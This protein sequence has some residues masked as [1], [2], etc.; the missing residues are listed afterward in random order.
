MSQNPNLA[1][2]CQA[3]C[4]GAKSAPPHLADWVI[5]T[6]E[7]LAYLVAGASLDENDSGSGQ[8]TRLEVAALRS[9]LTMAAADFWQRDLDTLERQVIALLEATTLSVAPERKKT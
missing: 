3:A 7:N 4:R 6:A 9:H 1:L 5:E 2:L 8:P